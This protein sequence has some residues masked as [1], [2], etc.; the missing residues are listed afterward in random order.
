MSEAINAHI[1]DNYPWGWRKTKRAQGS[2]EYLFMV[3][4]AL[5]I[6][7]I[8]L[9]YLRSS[10]STAGTA[11]LNFSSELS[12]SSD[13]SPTYGMSQRICRENENVSGM[14]RFL[15]NH[16]ELMGA[17]DYSNCNETTVT[18][19]PHVSTHHN[20]PTGTITTISSCI[21]VNGSVTTKWKIQEL[22][23]WSNAAEIE[24]DGQI[25][26]AVYFKGDGKVADYVGNLQYVAND[27]YV[28]VTS[29]PVQLSEGWHKL[30]I[31]FQ[32]HSGNYIYFQYLVKSNDV[33]HS[34]YVGDKSSAIT[35]YT[36]SSC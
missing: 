36:G 13:T 22:K 21:Y 33:W 20:V 16:E 25:V 34:Y 31:R 26:A 35:F 18:N 6:V 1:N 19:L 28:V 11:I 3:I 24:I 9:G 15:R 7:A 23:G 27:I 29:D 32:T 10:V 30:I 2:L 8:V 12:N 4:A 5:I 17:I 14:R